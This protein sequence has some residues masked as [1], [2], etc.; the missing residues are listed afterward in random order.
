MAYRPRYSMGMCRIVHRIHRE[1]YAIKR[2]VEDSQRTPVHHPDGL[3]QDI[4]VFT[5]FAFS[6]VTRESCEFTSVCSGFLP[7]ESGW[8]LQ[9]IC[10]SSFVR[11]VFTR[12]YSPTFPFLLAAF[13]LSALSFPN[14][15]SLSSL[16]LFSF[17]FYCWN[18]TPP[19]F[20]PTSLMLTFKFLFL[21]LPPL[22]PSLFPSIWLLVS[23]Y[24]DLDPHCVFLACQHSLFC[25]LPLHLSL[26]LS[27]SFLFP[28]HGV[29][30]F[31]QNTAQSKRERRRTRPVGGV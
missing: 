5:T 16:S 8:T 23:W 28:A 24:A 13:L 6:A 10:L 21:W 26:T 22:L 30:S 11:I 14:M 15:S 2:I 1:Q 3:R 7:V 27:L 19:L 12:L 18:T 29:H 25:R 20:L 17:S 9:T 31:Y 4:N